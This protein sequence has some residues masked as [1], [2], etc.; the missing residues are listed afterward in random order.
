[1]KNKKLL[2]IVVA[3]LTTAAMAFSIVGCQ[4][5]PE[6]DETGRDRT[7]S[8]GGSNEEPTL[9]DNL[10]YEAAER[11]M[12]ADGMGEYTKLA[13]IFAEASGAQGQ[14]MSLS[15]TPEAYILNL[16]G[17][18]EDDELNSTVIE[19]RA[20]V[21]GG[22]MYAGLTYKNDKTEVLSADM[23]IDGGNLILSIPKF[24][25]KYLAMDFGDIAD[26]IAEIEE[27]LAAMNMEV[28]ELPS[29][30]AIQNVIDATLDAYFD[31]ISVVTEEGIELEINGVTVT[32]DRNVIE[33]SD[34]AALEI[35]AAMLEAI[36]N[37]S[38]IKNFA[39]EFMGMADPTGLNAVDFVS[40]V[41]DLLEMIEAVDTNGETITMTAYVYGNQIVKRTVADENG[42][43]VLVLVTLETS[44]DYFMDLAIGAESEVRVTEV[45]TKD[46]GA[47]TGSATVKVSGHGMDFEVTVDYDGLAINDKYEV[48]AGTMKI[49]TSD[50]GGYKPVVNLE[51]GGDS[52]KG[53]LVLS[54]IKFAT[55]EMS[56]NDNY[57]GKPAPNVTSGN[58]IDLMDMNE[59]DTMAALTTF[60]SGYMQIAT[61]FENDGYDLIGY[62]LMN[63]MEDIAGLFAMLV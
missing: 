2:Y 48:T 62:F 16:L 41:E 4:S 23:W 47:Y 17:F 35:V 32:A 44:K 33:I 27:M 63:S 60:V 61:D 18:G 52:F 25:D 13:A 59:E 11:K 21:D 9:L 46:G 3:L 6:D 15:F 26:D 30:K 43:E 53:D 7:S 28:P 34:E 14:E 50:I 1:M 36:V 39:D 5:S 22:D 54:G 58:S 29:E 20:H 56:W 10:S 57:K 38:E 45:G 42:V 37:D 31:Q 51:F 55:V 12:L 40:V 8:D 24:I 19:M 49:S